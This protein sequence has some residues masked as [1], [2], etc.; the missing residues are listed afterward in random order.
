M[1]KQFDAIVSGKFSDTNASVVGQ[2]KVT[3]IAKFGRSNGG[4]KQ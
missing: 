4:D 3:S 2:K 1:S